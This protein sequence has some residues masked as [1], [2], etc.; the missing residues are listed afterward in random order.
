MSTDAILNQSEPNVILTA[1]ATKVYV[2]SVQNFK[3]IWC[4][5]MNSVTL[6]ML[7]FFNYVAETGNNKRTKTVYVMLISSTVAQSIAQVTRYFTTFYSNSLHAAQHV[8]G[9]IN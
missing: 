7:S 3:E 4:L 5:E 6:C 2:T 1:H 9:T 8:Q